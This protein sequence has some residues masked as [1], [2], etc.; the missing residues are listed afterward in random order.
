MD[1]WD[2]CCCRALSLP[3]L[4]G[5]TGKEGAQCGGGARNGKSLRTCGAI[6]L[7]L[8]GVLIVLYL[9]EAINLL[10]LSKVMLARFLAIFV[11]FLVFMETTAVKSLSY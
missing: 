7:D 9:N 3:L 10:S 2:R 6:T 5:K 4:R 1:M 11:S 8:V